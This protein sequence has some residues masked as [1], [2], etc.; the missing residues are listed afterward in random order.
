LGPALFQGEGGGL[1]QSTGQNDPD[2]LGESFR[3]DEEHPLPGTW[4]PTGAMTLDRDGLRPNGRHYVLTKADDYLDKD[5]R[6]EVVFVVKATEADL[7]FVGLGEVDRDAPFNEPGGSLY[8][9][10]HP[11]GI[12]NGTIGLANGR[13]T[14][15]TP[16]GRI[17]RGGKYRASIEKKGDA[18]TFQVDR[19]TD[20]PSEHDCAHTIPDI[21]SFGPY[22]EGHKTHLFFGGAGTFQQVRLSER[23]S[24][25]RPQPRPVLPEA[26]PSIPVIPA[27]KL[28]GKKEIKLDVPFDH[29]RTGGAGRYLIFL[30]EEAKKLMV[31]DAA[32]AKLTH[33]IDVPDNAKFAASFDKLLIAN[34][35]ERL[36]QR[37]D[38]HSG[39]MEKMAAIPG[40]G[41]IGLALMGCNGRGPLFQRVGNEFVLFDIERMGPAFLDVRGLGDPGWSLQCRISADGQ[42]VALWA[43]DVVLPINY[44]LVRLGRK[45]IVT[46]SPD[47]FAFPGRWAMPSAD[48]SLIFRTDSGIYDADMRPLPVRALKGMTL[49]P[50]EDPRFFLAVREGPDASEL[51]ICTSADRQ[52]VFKVAGVEKMTASRARTRWGRFLGEP[53]VHYLPS[54][55]VLITLPES[56]DRVVMRPLNLLEA[57][58]GT[59]EDY[60]LVLSWPNRRV[61]EVTELQYRMDVRSRSA[62]LQYELEE[63][64]KG[65]TVSA[66]GE[67]R[68]LV[69]RSP[70]PVRVRIRVRSASGKEVEHAF[71]LTVVRPDPRAP[72]Q[73]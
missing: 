28:T 10:I 61:A 69:S 73:P 1:T 72:H 13:V 54:A 66:D 25:S 27:P 24:S 35:Q 34:P 33:R 42:A 32:Q 9:R 70:E 2:E 71:N 60:L 45:N 15:T 22:L 20:T 62:P 5:F 47:A 4:Q 55:N 43:G 51:L 63:G 37:W 16:I 48:G 3:L 26:P 52:V 58:K 30:N 18:I 17:F 36:L 8:L 44:G 31:F 11:P 65:M 64:P 67:V 57:L 38:L 19:G 40:G 53:R 68:W 49:L 14:G 29:V 59:G 56:N 23:P 21:R 41:A 12:D 39:K 50:T 46:S 7:A 6:L